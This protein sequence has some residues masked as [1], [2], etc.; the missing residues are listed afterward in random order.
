MRKAA[1]HDPRCS[2]RDALQLIVSKWS[3]LI[4]PAL[5][6]GPLRNGELLRKVSGISQKVLTQTLRELE[7]NGLVVR[8]D[9]HTKPRHVDYGLSRLGASLAR[10][11]RV[12]D[13]WAARHFPQLDAA[14]ENYDTQH[15]RR[16]RINAR[17]TG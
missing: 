10:T 2:A 14:R 7:R 1:A 12:L 17:S 3:L 15:E 5:A 6:G 13:R 16:P 11:L 9:M 4:I 8:R